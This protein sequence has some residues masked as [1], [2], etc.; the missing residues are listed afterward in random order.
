MKNLILFESRQYIENDMERLYSRNKP[1][2]D[3]LIETYLQEQK[4]YT[5]ASWNYADA[6]TVSL[7]EEK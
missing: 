4:K 6:S 7:L 2:L 1:H 3:W 5:W